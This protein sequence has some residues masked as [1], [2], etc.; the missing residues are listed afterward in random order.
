M[1]EDLSEFLKTDE[2][3]EL[4]A[5]H[6]RALRA[7]AKREQ[8]T[9]ELVEAVYQAARDAALGMNIPKVT[10]PKPDKRKSEPEHAILLARSHRPTTARLRR[11][12]SR[13]LARR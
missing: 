2:L 10:A 1:S 7:L 8:A 4:K 6:C 13:N 11:C 3:Q 12:G 9:G 5:A